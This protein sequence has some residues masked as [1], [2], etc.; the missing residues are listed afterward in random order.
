VE[1]IRL[2]T[3]LKGD[4]AKIVDKAILIDPYNLVFQKHL[5]EIEEA[6]SKT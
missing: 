2:K 3:G 5:K 4:D 6:T 1:K